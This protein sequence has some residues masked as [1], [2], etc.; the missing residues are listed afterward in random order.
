MLKNNKGITLIALVITIIVLLILAGVSI[1]MLTGENGILTQAENSKEDTAKAEAAD[2][3]NM[4]LNGEF[5]NLLADG[6]FT[7][8]KDELLANNGLDVPDGEAAEYKITAPTGELNPT[9]NGIVLTIAST[10]YEEDVKGSIS[11]NSTTGDYT[12]KRAK[13]PVELREA[14]E[15][16]G[17]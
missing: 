9:T 11:Y 10:K 5:A 8:T 3:I 1:A 13:Y 12:I 16:A 2:K 14:A 4:A 15:G 7:G 17:D 6:E